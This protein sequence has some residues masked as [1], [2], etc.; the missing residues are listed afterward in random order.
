MGD[1]ANQREDLAHGRALADQI[2]EGAG[3]IDGAP[4]PAILLLERTA[5]DRPFDRQQHGFR[6]ER[7]GDVVEGAYAHGF[8]GRVDAP[9]RG[10]QDDRRLGSDLTQLAHE[11][12]A[13]LAGHLDVAEHCVELDLARHVEGFGCT[14]RV[15]HGEALLAEERVEHLPHRGVVIDDHESTGFGHH[16]RSQ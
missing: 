12:D 10:H 1:L 3:L 5:L 4:Q 8:D 13:G 7:L 15:A 6:L 16:G 9:E 11:L 14:G 2:S